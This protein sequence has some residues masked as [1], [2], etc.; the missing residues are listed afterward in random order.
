[1]LEPTITL[2]RVRTLRYTSRALRLV[3]QRSGR[4][5][6]EL[7]IT[8]QSIGAAVWLLWGGLLHE[9]AEFRERRE[10]TITIDDV[11]DLLDEYWFKKDRTLK[12]LGPLFAEAVVQAGVFS[13]AGSD[14]GKAQP[15]TGTASHASGSPTGSPH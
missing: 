11:C 1:M 9:D 6:G 8:Y 2:D 4:I 10:P 14:E 15:E 13:R 5:L 7:L 3:E 12:E